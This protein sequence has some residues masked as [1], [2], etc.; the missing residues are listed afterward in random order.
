M[1]KSAK[2]RNHCFATP[3]EILEEANSHQQ[4]KKKLGKRQM[5]KSV[6]EET[7]CHHPH[8]LTRLW[9]PKSGSA[10]CYVLTDVV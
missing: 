1:K 3:N 4:I 9:T 2:Q 8:L 5:K 7:T 6:A 10:R